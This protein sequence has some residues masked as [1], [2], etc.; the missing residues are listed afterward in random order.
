MVARLHHV[1]FR[2]APKGSSHRY[3]TALGRATRA[4]YGRGLGMIPI[5]PG[6]KPKEYGDLVCDVESWR[7]AATCDA[8]DRLLHN[9][10]KLHSSRTIWAPTPIR[11]HSTD[12]YRPYPINIMPLVPSCPTP[13]R[14]HSTDRYSPYPINI[15]PLVPSCRLGLAWQLSKLATRFKAVCGSLTGHPRAKQS[16]A[17][18]GDDPDEM[19]TEYNRCGHH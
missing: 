4:G 6:A 16:C 7:R 10:C 17:A 12:R 11:A 9:H 19:G 14:A 3:D 15:M 2:R 5:R 8:P 13:I 1:G 18:I